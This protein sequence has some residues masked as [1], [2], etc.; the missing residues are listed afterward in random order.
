MHHTKIP[1]K[2]FHRF[3]V[4]A[5]VTHVANIEYNAAKKHTMIKPIVITI[6][7][8]SWSSDWMVTIGWNPVNDGPTIMYTIVVMITPTIP[9]N[10]SNCAA[11]KSLSCVVNNSCTNILQCTNNNISKH[12]Y[13]PEQW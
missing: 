4:I 13:Y 10:P 3:F 1:R 11:G 12:K 2:F 8:L 6:P 9:S 5:D 7:V